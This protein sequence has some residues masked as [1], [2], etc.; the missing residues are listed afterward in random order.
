MSIHGRLAMVISF[1]LTASLHVG[2]LVAGEAKG[3]KPKI[4]K[5]PRGISDAERQKIVA[6]IPEKA[7]ARPAK[8]RRLL[9][10]DLNVNYGGHGSIAHAN[11][12]FTL[13][14]KKTGAYDTVGSRDPE[15][16]RPASLRQFDAV[17]LNN[18]VGNLFT[19]AELRKSLI[20]FVSEGGGL[21]GIHGTSVAFTRWTEG[22][23]EDWP[24]FGLMLGARGASHRISTERVFIKLDDPDHP[25]NRAFGGK[26]FEFRDEYFR[27]HDPYSR[28]RVRV[29]LSIDTQKTDMNQGKNFGKV[30]RPDNDYALAWVRS[31][32]K[33]RVFYSTIGHNP[34]VFWDR[35]MLEFY[36]A[37]IQFALGDLP[38]PTAPTSAKSNQGTP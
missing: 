20:D 1:L 6:A 3:P 8:S 5:S 22:A 32:G 38:G 7:P 12:A 15:V 10:F 17:F 21:L 25:I 33:G 18:T 37:A 2:L 36:L 24:E 26:G 4:A 13:M 29:L 35:R 27:F 30:E 14:G 23:A 34:Y 11:L 28:S 9:I 31:H 16:F 19:D